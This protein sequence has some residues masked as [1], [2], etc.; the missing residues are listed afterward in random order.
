MFTWSQ[1]APP[2]DPLAVPVFT[3]TVEGFAAV[4]PPPTHYPGLLT[5]STGPA[6]ATAKV[7]KFGEFVNGSFTQPLSIDPLTGEPRLLSNWLSSAATNAAGQG[8]G[9]VV[10]SVLR[11]T[12][13]SGNDQGHLTVQLQTHQLTGFPGS[14]P[15]SSLPAGAPPGS[16]AVWISQTFTTYAEPFLLEIVAK[17]S[18]PG[19][20][21][22]HLLID[23]VSVG[24]VTT[25]APDSPLNQDAM[26]TLRFPVTNPALLGR[27]VPFTI[28]LQHMGWD[29]RVDLDSV[30][31]IPRC[32]TADIAGPGP[33]SGFDGELTADDI[34]Q[35]VSWFTSGD[36][37]A[38][39]AGPGPVDG[40]DAELTAD[41]LILFINR[42]S[43]GC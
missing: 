31:T 34:I 32:S 36:T 26:T 14:L 17:Q 41:D 25:D 21:M 10:P 3:T 5:P 8:S 11:T 18:Q 29:L 27:S 43:A 12:D 1:I 2:R 6:F 28:L 35:F 38:D 40:P 42:F 23:G 20:G 15:P 22:L 39:I 9:S 19:P 24:A 30:R 33:T 16:G 13:Q 37:R 7:P 4:I